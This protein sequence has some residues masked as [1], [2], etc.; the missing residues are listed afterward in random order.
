MIAAGKILSFLVLALSVGACA[1]TKDSRRDTPWLVPVSSGEY[2]IEIVSINGVPLTPSTQM[3]LPRGDTSEIV[4]KCEGGQLSGQLQTI[5]YP[6]HAPLPYNIW[7]GGG[8]GHIS[9]GSPPR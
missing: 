8:R 5:L 7:C 4:F 1:T 9:L 3:H 6:F 2:S